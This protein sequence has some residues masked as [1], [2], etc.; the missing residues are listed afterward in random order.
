[1]TS[2]THPRN[3]HQPEEDVHSYRN[4]QTCIVLEDKTD[5]QPEYRVKS[6]VEGLWLKTFV[7]WKFKDGA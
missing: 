6:V 2:V 3:L 5:I 1:M 7:P 4:H